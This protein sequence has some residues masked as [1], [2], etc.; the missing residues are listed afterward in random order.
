MCKT[1]MLHGENNPEVIGGSYDMNT[2][3]KIDRIVCALNLHDLYTTVKPTR[4]LMHCDG[5][6]DFIAMKK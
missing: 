3:F 1:V 2:S 6:I 4:Y 5:G